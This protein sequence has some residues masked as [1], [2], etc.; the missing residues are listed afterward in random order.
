MLFRSVKK[1]IDSCQKETEKLLTK[2][3]DKLLTMANVLLEKETIY[4][5][6]VDL[7]ISGKNKDEIIAYIDGKDKKPAD[8]DGNV[9]QEN[10]EE[11]T[12]KNEEKITENTEKTTKSVDELLKE[13]EARETAILEKEEKSEP[14]AEEKSEVKDDS[15]PQIKAKKTAKAKAEEKTETKPKT[16]RKRTVKKTEDDS[17]KT[18]K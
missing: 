10:P 14:Q 1:I 4:E 18:E 7:I 3:K 8:V 11:K 2:H 15:K 13:A 12:A 17:Q 16:T 9:S 5:E 6:E